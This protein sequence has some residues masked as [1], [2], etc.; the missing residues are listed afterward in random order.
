MHKHRTKRIRKN[1][2]KLW[3]ATATMAIDR[4]PSQFLMRSKS[5]DISKKSGQ[6]L[7]S[8]FGRTF[9]ADEASTS[10]AMVCTGAIWPIYTRHWTRHAYWGH[11]RFFFFYILA[12]C[13]T[14]RAPPFISQTRTHNRIFVG[15]SQQLNHFLLAHTTPK[16]IDQI[17]TANGFC[18]FIFST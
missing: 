16:R 4:E 5:S 6:H 15:Y 7:F 17:Y 2:Q 12:V 18:I 14:N 3:R 1:T 13:R 10:N 11:I 9:I 8:P